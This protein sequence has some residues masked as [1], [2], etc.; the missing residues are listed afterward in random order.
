MSCPPGFKALM[1][2][3]KP[4]KL[5]P[6]RLSPP[7]NWE[8]VQALVQQ[9][10]QA[11]LYIIYGSSAPFADALPVEQEGFKRVTAGVLVSGSWIH[12]K[13]TENKNGEQPFN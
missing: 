8:A 4:V 1:T 6:I 3:I 2:A 5:A 12:T 9:G 11:R 13:V 7:A 10:P